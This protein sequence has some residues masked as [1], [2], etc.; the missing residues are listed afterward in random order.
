MPALVGMRHKPI[1]KEHYE[2]LV[3]R[4][5]AKKDALV[6]C[7]AKLLWIIYGI[8]TRREPFNPTHATT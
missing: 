7:M 2:R 8:L 5:K 4:G 6:A 1:L 3:E